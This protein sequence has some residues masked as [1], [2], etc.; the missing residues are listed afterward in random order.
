MVLKSELRDPLITSASKR[1]LLMTLGFLVFAS[2]RCS[3]TI[4]F[5]VGRFESFPDFSGEVLSEFLSWIVLLA[6]MPLI[7]WFARRLVPGKKRIIRFVLSHAAIMVFVGYLH[8]YLWKVFE[9]SFQEPFMPMAK[10]ML[11]EPRVVLMWTGVLNNCY[12]YVFLVGGYYLL[13]Q[14]RDSRN[15]ERERHELELKTSELE[16]QLVQAQLL[17]LRQ[18]LDPHFLFNALNSISV[19]IK[20]QPANAKKMLL[21]LS[22]LLRSTLMTDRKSFVILKDEISFLERYLEIEKMRFGDQLIIEFSINTMTESIQVPS[23]IMQPL[24]ENAI[25]HGIAASSSANLIR[26]EALVEGDQLCLTVFDN[27]RG[28]SDDYKR[29]IGLEN[30]CKRLQAHYS[31]QA[32]FDLVHVAGQGTFATLQLPHAMKP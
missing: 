5:F 28:P 22:K 24:V 4:L 23:M 29:G 26:I 31:D 2:Y 30:V 13:L 6:L 12:K 10:M 25:R 9:F 18:Q 16:A 21:H 14:L 19:L 20:D 1:W 17:T 8:T 27:G 32:Q 15:A 7:L 3:V 11:L